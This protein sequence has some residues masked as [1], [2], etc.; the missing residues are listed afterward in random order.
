MAESICNVIVFVLK[1]INVN[2]ELILLCLMSIKNSDVKRKE[3]K[4]ISCIYRNFYVNKDGVKLS[5]CYT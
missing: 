5:D 1:T 2:S 4:N 3:F